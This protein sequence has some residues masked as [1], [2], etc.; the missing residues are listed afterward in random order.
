VKTDDVQFTTDILDQIQSLYCLDPSRI[1]VTGKSDG[2]GF[3]NVLACDPVLS[4][5]IAAFAPVSGAYYIDLS[6]DETCEPSTVHI[7]CSAGRTDIPLIA[8]HG[9]NDTTISYYGGVRKSECL[10]TIPNF[11]QQWAGRDGLGESN[12]TIPL[13]ALDSLKYLYGNGKNLGLV[14]LVFESNIGHDWP[15]TA[16][17]ADNLVPGHHIA[18]YNATPIILEFFRRHPLNILE[19]FRQI[20]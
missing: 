11:I 18:S 13:A 19:T 2:G 12:L 6:A 7:P 3:C 8:F 20:L 10:P 5:R 9:G 15:S 17:N 4:T 1:T 16:P 14:E